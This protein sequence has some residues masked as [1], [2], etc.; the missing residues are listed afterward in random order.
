MGLLERIKIKNISLLQKRIDRLK[1][2]QWNTSIIEAGIKEVNHSLNSGCKSLVVYG[3]PQSGK[4]EFMIALT[5]SLLDQNRSTIFVIMNDNTELESQNY[6]RF[7]SAPEITPSPLSVEQFVSLPDAS[8]KSPQNRIIFCRKN[9]NNLEKIIHETRY[10]KDRIIIDDEADF[11]TPDTKVN[12]QATPPSVINEL[13]DKLGRLSVS[14]RGTYIGVTATPGRLDLNCTF[15]NQ[16]DKWVF[17]DSHLNYKGRDFFFPITDKQKDKSNFNLHLLSDQ[18]DEEKEL[19]ESLLRFLVRAAISNIVDGKTSIPDAYSMLVHTDGKVSTHEQ[20]EKLIRKHLDILIDQENHRKKCEAY[21]EI[22]H[23]FA[24]KE[25]KKHNLELDPIDDVLSFILT[26]IAKSTVLVIN[27]NKSKNNVREA[28]QPRDV[29]TIAIGGN[30]VS[31]GLTFEQLLT[32]YFSRS[33]KGKLQQNT[34]IQRARMFGNRPYSRFFELCIPTQLYDDWV[35]CF[36]DHELSM[37]SA[38]SGDYLHIYG[39]SNLPADRASLKKSSTIKVGDEMLIGEVANIPKGL[40]VVLRTTKLKTFDLI[41]KLMKEPSFPKKLIDE[42]L[43]VHVKTMC[44]LSKNEPRI[45]LDQN[46]GIFCPGDKDFDETTIT[47]KRG[48]LVSQSIHNREAYSGRAI[49]MPVKNR[50]GQMRFYFKFNFGKNTLKR[51]K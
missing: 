45:F 18:Y 9:K 17:L 20:D 12:K 49:L 24:K 15:A 50:H 1:S 44:K 25:I 5:C 47:R 33:V 2:K 39:E 43:L 48:G 22:M 34:Y 10:L 41:E 51:V 28:C 46:R 38:K 8:K 23:D 19:K 13:V 32:F 26:N 29:F 3:E 36:F 6:D 35:N 21:V 16:S 14:N 27:S 11:A 30:L 40:E 42:N 4:T 37:L 7:K 31:R